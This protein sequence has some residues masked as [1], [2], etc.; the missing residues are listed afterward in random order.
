MKKTIFEMFS[1]SNNLLFPIV[2][3]HI[4]KRHFFF[5]KF[6]DFLIFEGQNGNKYI[7]KSV[8]TYIYPKSLERDLLNG[9]DIIMHYL[10][11]SLICLMDRSRDLKIALAA[12]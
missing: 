2:C 10:I 12:F 4:R 11:F 9:L 6:S 7:I 1:S 5:Y 3:C 8:K